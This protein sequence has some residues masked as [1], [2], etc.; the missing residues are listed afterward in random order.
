MI[1]DL[2]A[3]TIAAGIAVLLWIVRG[4]T[5]KRAE[6]RLANAWDEVLNDPHY[7][8]RRASEERTQK[9]GRE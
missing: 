2:F 7:S 9:L 1:L 5:K 4:E 8:E 3:V 6:E